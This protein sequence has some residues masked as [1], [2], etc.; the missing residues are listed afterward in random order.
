MGVLVVYYPESRWLLEL[1]S[2]YHFEYITLQFLQFGWNLIENL[3]E[4]NKYKSSYEWPSVIDRAVVRT[5]R[6]YDLFSLGRVLY[7]ELC[8]P[9]KFPM[10]YQSCQ[11]IWN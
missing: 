10:S 5:L 3:P 7:R 2:I 4:I 1:Y 8:A 9:A 6:H 11:R